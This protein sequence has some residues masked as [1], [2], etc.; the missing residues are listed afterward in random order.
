[1][2]RTNVAWLR[3]G[4]GEGEGRDTP[5]DCGGTGCV[6]LSP[7]HASAVKQGLVTKHLNTPNELLVYQLLGY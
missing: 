4:E 3:L 6:N 1:M 7:I 2:E 5:I